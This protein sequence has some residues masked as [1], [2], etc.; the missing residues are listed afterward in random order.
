MKKIL[1]KI[2]A[3]TA[4]LAIV[5]FNCMAVWTDP[6][7][8]AKYIEA[9]GDAKY[10]DTKAGSIA[11]IFALTGW[12][13]R[14]LGFKFTKE[15]CQEYLENNYDILK[16]NLPNIDKEFLEEKYNIYNRHGKDEQ[17][18]KKE[19]LNGFGTKKQGNTLKKI[20][21]EL[22]VDKIKRPQLLAV[23]TNLQE[24]SGVKLDRQAK[25]T[26]PE[27]LKWFDENWQKIAPYMNSQE[28]NDCLN[29]QQLTVAGTDQ[30]ALHESDKTDKKSTLSNGDEN[31]S[32][33]DFNKNGNSSDYFDD[34]FWSYDFSLS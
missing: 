4:F 34:D 16:E 1:S 33:F 30:N 13:P 31:F 20:K 32:F 7:I 21:K 12:G 25:R 29:Q 9:T 28:I 6:E 18:R 5:P 11:L 2:I 26:M 24:Q 14:M 22:E 23:A 3:G 10:T 8:R 15:R 19:R 27:L 17:T